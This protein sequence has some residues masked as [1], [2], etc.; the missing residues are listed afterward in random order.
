MS[1]FTSL[2]DAISQ[3][4]LA[5]A[6]V[7]NHMAFT[8]HLIGLKMSLADFK[9]YSSKGPC[10]N[11]AAARGGNYLYVRLKDI[12]QFLAKKKHN[13]SLFHTNRRHTYRHTLHTHSHRQ[14][15]LTHSTLL[16]SSHN[17]S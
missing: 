11:R 7:I 8:A 10:A 13:R 2:C 4:T 6:S 16:L 17:A 12:R 3:S 5:F 9:C 14:R 15:V 1:Q